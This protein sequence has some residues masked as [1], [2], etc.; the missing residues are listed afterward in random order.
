MRRER[1][2]K[3]NAAM[4]GAGIDV[5]VL[6]GQQNVS[7]A[8]GARM[9]AADHLRAS[10]WRSVAVLERGAPWPHLYTDFPEGAPSEL[11]DEYL[12]RAI[13]VETSAGAAELA[14]RLAAGKIAIDDASLPLSPNVPRYRVR[15]LLLTSSTS[16]R[17][18]DC[19]PSCPSPP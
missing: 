1:V 19:R 10:W 18:S 14:G 3:I 4:D 17:S 9:P 13:E 11:P 12:H 16:L 6:C 8:T 2:A 5:L 7:F 15:S